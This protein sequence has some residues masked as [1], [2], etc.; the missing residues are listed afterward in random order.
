MGGR[1]PPRSRLMS[2]SDYR[3]DQDDLDDVEF[4]QA[5]RALRRRRAITAVAAAGVLTALL[6]IPWKQ[7][8]EASGRV[9]PAR[10]ARVRSEVPGVV[11]EVKRQSGDTVQEGDVIAVLDSDV[12]R[13]ALEGARLGL[14]RE[15]QKLADLELRLQ[16]NR[17]LR[18]GS[19]VGAQHARTRADAAA[20]VHEA[21]IEDLEPAASAVIE[22]VRTFTIKARGELMIDGR[23]ATAFRG[24]PIHKRSTRR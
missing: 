12:Q 15:R 4:E 20:N 22:G 14:T 6:A 3:P 18:D 5:L 23:R 7:T 24:E 9:A 8:L 1:T 17:I 11:R 13:D 2:H 19:D 10:W 16:Q 21:R